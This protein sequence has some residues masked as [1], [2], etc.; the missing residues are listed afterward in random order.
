MIII[1]V[2]LT[3]FVKFWHYYSYHDAE[4]ASNIMQNCPK[5]YQKKIN[6]A[7]L[8]KISTN[9]VLYIKVLVGTEMHKWLIG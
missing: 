2:L 3:Q 9:K 6:I 5:E 8:Q 1:L 4:L 7:Q